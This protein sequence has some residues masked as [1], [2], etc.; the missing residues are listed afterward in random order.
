MKLETIILETD[1]LVV[2]GGTSGCYA[3]LTLSKQ[4][5]M[6]IIVVDKANIK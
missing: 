5:D 3:A 6:N 4:E 1:V 2:G